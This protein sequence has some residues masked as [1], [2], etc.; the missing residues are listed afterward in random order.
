MVFEGLEDGTAGFVGV[1]TVGETAVFREAE[2]LGEVAGEFLG[3]HVEGAEAFDSRSVDE[4]AGDRRRVPPFLRPVGSKRPSVERDRLRDRRGKLR[5][6]AQRDHFTEGRGVLTEVVG[7]GD[8]G[9]AEVGIRDEAIDE[10]GFPHA[11]V[12][13]EQRDLPFEQGT[14]I[15]D[16]I[17][18]GG[19]DLFAGIADCLVELHHHLLVVQL[20]GVK[21]VG[22][23][24]DQHHR[25]A[26]GL[27]GGQE[28]VD[29]GRGGLGIVDRDHQEGLI[30]VGGDN[31]ALFG[32]VLGA[33][34]DVVATVFDGG[35]E[36]SRARPFLRPVGS[37]RPSV[38]RGKLRDREAYGDTIT[39]GDGVGGADA[40]EAEGAFDFTINQLAIVRQDGVPAASIFND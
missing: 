9:G 18:R 28:T 37:K 25:D 27:G 24:E 26:I 34:D 8:F 4:P 31:V 20:V 13:T 5:N 15:F 17:T 39:D 16:A 30:D 14:Q 11:T 2:D 36:G 22:L 35:D 19:R 12:A 6:R 32:E 23:V 3:G 38:E 40:F 10:R 1:G 29:E 7:G 21:A 33:T